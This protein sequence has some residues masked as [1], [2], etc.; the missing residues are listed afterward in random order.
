MLKTVDER[1]PEEKRAFDDLTELADQLLRWVFV[2]GGSC[3]G[4]GGV[5]GCVCVDEEG[6]GAVA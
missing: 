3:L 6:V 1:T 2:F 5:D 4:G